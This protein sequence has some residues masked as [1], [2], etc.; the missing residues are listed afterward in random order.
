MIIR[1]CLSRY[2]HQTVRFHSIRRTNPLGIQMLSSKLHEQ[3]FSSVGEPTY[4]EINVEKS[5]K[6]LCQ[7]DLGS[8]ESEILENIEFDLP[9]LESQNLNEHFEI[10]ARQQSKSYVDLIHQLIKA[11]VPLQPTQWNYAKGWT[12][13]V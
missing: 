8:H 13:F 6:H 3:L 7:F 10:I 5:K 4:Q 9:K 2:F 12:K 11:K 1:Q